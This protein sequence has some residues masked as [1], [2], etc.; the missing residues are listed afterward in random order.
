MTARP[1]LAATDG[2]PQSLAAVHWAAEEAVRRGTALRLV[3][4]WPRP[5]GIYLEQL[6]N[7]GAE[8]LT[9]VTHEVA[10]RYPELEVESV[11]LGATPVE[12]LLEAAADGELLVLGSRGL[13]GFTGLLVG[14]VSLALAGRSPVPVVVLRPDTAVAEDRAPGRATDVVVGVGDGASA[15][16]VLGFAFSRAQER[17]A[18]VVAVHGWD[19]PALW[20]PPGTMVIPI[21]SATMESAAREQSAQALSPWQAKYPQVPVVAGTEVGGGAKA[22]VDAS[23]GAELVVIGRRIRK[24][25]TGAHLGLTAHAVLHHAHAPVAVVPHI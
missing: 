1:V 5:V 21:D 16:E 4:V 3:H 15:D 6:Q 23:D 22:L 2:S 12:G 19:V 25:A 9:H 24:H 8:L 10:G 17:G 13:G 14:S 7:E 11:L 18:R 20:A